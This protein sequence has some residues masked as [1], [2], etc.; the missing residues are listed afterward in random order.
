MKKIII[1]AIAI[2]LA[3]AIPYCT[4]GEDLFSILPWG[5]TEEIE[6]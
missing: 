1:L 5:D 2:I 4:G 3:L 6:L